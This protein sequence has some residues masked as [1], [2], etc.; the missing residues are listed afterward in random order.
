MQVLMRKKSDLTYVEK[1][2]KVYNSISKT[3]KTIKCFH[4]SII[5]ILLTNKQKNLK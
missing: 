1:V 2:N 5:R 4:T 3:T